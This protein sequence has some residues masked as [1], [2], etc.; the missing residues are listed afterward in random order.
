MSGAL[1]I[2]YAWSQV[3]FQVLVPLVWVPYFTPRDSSVAFKWFRFS[4]SSFRVRLEFEFEF[5][6]QLWFRLGVRHVEQFPWRRLIGESI[7]RQ[8]TFVL[9]PLLH[10]SH[11]SLLFA[12]SSCDSLFNLL[13]NV[14]RSK[15]IK[16]SLWE[17]PM[18]YETLALFCQL[19]KWN[20]TQLKFNA[21]IWIR[22]ELL[23]SIPSSNRSWSWSRRRSQSPSISNKTQSHEAYS[24]KIYKHFPMKIVSTH[25]IA[26][27]FLPIS[28]SLFVSVSHVALCLC[29]F[30]A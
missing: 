9:T 17:G 6:F 27:L 22:A 19:P 26:S 28:L 12:P 30:T 29:V 13:T 5:C 18:K 20:K 16:N 15:T 1:G 2:K 24:S 10:C 8:L 25:A 3:G 4:F 14:K 21:A 23:K 7:K 11:L